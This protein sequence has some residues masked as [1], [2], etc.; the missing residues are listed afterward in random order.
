MKHCLI[1]SDF[2]FP[3]DQYAS[4]TIHPRVCAFAYPAPRAVPWMA[5]L[6][7]PF[8]TSRKDMRFIATLD[9]CLAYVSRIIPFVHT[10]VLQHNLV[11]F[12]KNALVIKCFFHQC[13]VMRVGTG[14]CQAYRQSVTFSEQASLCSTLGSIGW[15]WTCFFPR[16]AVPLSSLH[17]SIATSNQCLRGCRTPQEPPSTSRQT[18]RALR[19]TESTGVPCSRSQTHEA[20]LSTDSQSSAHRKFHRELGAKKLEVVRLCVSV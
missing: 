4:K 6:L 2:L 3:A 7:I 12:W 10:H 14:H 19:A 13:L 17:P 9:D 5:F 8:F 1:I 20:K 16:Q 15:I 18:H 11:R